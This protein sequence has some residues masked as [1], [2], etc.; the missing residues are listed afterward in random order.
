MS[1]FRDIF[2]VGTLKEYAEVSNAFVTAYSRQSFF[3][4]TFFIKY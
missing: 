2:L 4:H 3:T 1:R